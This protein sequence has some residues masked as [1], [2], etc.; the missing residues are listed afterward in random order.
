MDT[1]RVKGLAG[2]GLEVPDLEVARNFYTKFGLLPEGDAAGGMLALKSLLASGPEVLVLQGGAKR[3]HHIAFTVDGADLHRFAQQLDK[4]GTPLRT[5]PFGPLREG[6]WFQDPWGTWVNLTPVME[7][8]SAAGIARPPTAASGERVDRHYW[9]ELDH[10]VRP[11]RL[12]HLLMFTD[13]WEHAE[14]YYAG[15]LGLRT[16]DRAAGKV[17][18]MAGGVGVRD[19]HCFGLI[20]STHRGFQ[21]ASFHVNTFD[22]INMAAGRMRRA[23]YKEGFGP[24]RHLLASNLFYYVRD[25]WGSWM[26]YY[27]DMDRISEAWQAR[28]WTELPYIWG[29]EWSPEFWGGEMNANLEKK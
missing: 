26:E 5:Q 14:A 20:K 8:A 29:P 28:D 13:E 17:S 25:P 24:G 23:G 21:H 10:D 18:F 11:N 1:A 19:H 12:G 7:D 16:S 3:L 22:D 2:F 15:A 27:S 9:Q 4:L 6:V